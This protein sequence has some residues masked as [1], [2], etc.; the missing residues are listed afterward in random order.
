MYIEELLL[1]IIT[2]AAL[3]IG[4]IASIIIILGVLFGIIN[5]LQIQFNGKTSDEKIHDRKKVRQKLGE[6]LLLG[7][8]VLIAADIIESIA[9]PSLSELARLGT[10][11]IIRTFISY[12]LNK[13]IKENN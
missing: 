7:L 12:F 8:E 13:E 4:L 10:I 3:I 9:N 5:L 11:V 2:Y 6:N 1:R